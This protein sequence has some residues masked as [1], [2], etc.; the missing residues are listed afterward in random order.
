M[1]RRQSRSTMDTETARVVKAARRLVRTSKPMV[2]SNRTIGALAEA[3]E[4]QQ[5]LEDA[6]DALDYKTE[7]K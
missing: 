1:S 2:I 6:L 5:E 3:W 7:K 4:A